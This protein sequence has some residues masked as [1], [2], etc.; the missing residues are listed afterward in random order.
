MNTA[1]MELLRSKL[2][3]FGFEKTFRNRDSYINVRDVKGVQYFARCLTK[4]SSGDVRF[5]E[6]PINSAFDYL[7]IMA[8]NEAGKVKDIIRFTKRIVQ[9]NLENIRK[10]G[11]HPFR[12][13]S[14]TKALGE[15]L[16]PSTNKA[17]GA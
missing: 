4:K 16:Y 14:D 9:A 7:L 2:P 12:W 5:D 17:S 11:Q 10:D 3:E 8:K 13:N 15:I 1:N 6:R